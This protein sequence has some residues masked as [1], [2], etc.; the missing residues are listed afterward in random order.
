D[1]MLC[2]N[3]PTDRSHEITESLTQ[4][5]FNAYQMHRLNLRYLTMTMYDATFTGVTPIF[6]KD[7]LDNTLGQVLAA[8]GK[9]Q[10]RMAETEKYPHVTVFFSGGRELEVEGEK[11]IMRASPKVATYDLAPEMSA[12]ELR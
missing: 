6:E 12:Y 1:L 5:D 2:F 4:Q 7:N 8:H 9:T 10:I 11:R 3:F